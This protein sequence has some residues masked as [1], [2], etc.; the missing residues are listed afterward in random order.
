MCLSVVY[1][2]SLSLSLSLSLSVCHSTVL[3][4]KRAHI[5][6]FRVIVSFRKGT[7]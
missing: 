1:I 3:M 2:V 6:S 5:L 7:A 4:N